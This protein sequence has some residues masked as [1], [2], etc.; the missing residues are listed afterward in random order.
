MSRIR[1]D[2]Q[3]RNGRHHPGAQTNGNGHHPEA[4]TEPA[5]SHPFGNVTVPALPTL[6]VSS[7]ATPLERFSELIARAFQKT[8]V[9]RRIPK[10]FRRIFRQQG[11][12]NKLTLEISRLLLQSDV[13]LEKKNEELVAYLTAQNYWLQALVKA[14]DDENRSVTKIASLVNQL[15]VKSAEL[16]KLNQVSDQKLGSLSESVRHLQNGLREAQQDSSHTFEKLAAVKS[17]ATALSHSIQQFQ[18]QSDQD[19]NQLQEL[20]RRCSAEFQRL[21]A[22]KADYA[23]VDE[24]LSE[25]H[26]HSISIQGRQ[27]RAEAEIADLKTS[28]SQSDNSL[29]ELRNARFG[30]EQKFADL[31]NE[32]VGVK[33]QLAAREA[34]GDAT[35]RELIPIREQLAAR[36]AQANAT[37]QELA[38]LR[39]Q[40]AAREAQ[41]DAT[42]RE[43]IPIREQLAAREAQANATAA[44]LIPIRERLA[45]REAQA[46]A[47]AESLVADTKWLHAALAAETKARE[48]VET[49]LQGYRA[50]FESLTDA[51]RKEVREERNDLTGISSELAHTKAVVEYLQKQNYGIDARLVAD[52]SFLKGELHLIKRDVDALFGEQGDLPAAKLEAVPERHAY[53]AFY[54]AFENKFRG[55]REV[56][57]ARAEPYL[58]DL[59]RAGVTRP[60]S[61]ILDLGCGRG[62]WLELLKENE[63]TCEGVDSNLCMV[64]ECHERGLAVTEGDALSFLRSKRKASYAAVTGFHIIEHLPFPV[65]MEVMREVYRVLRRGGVAI[66]ETPNPENVLVGSNRFYSDPTHL[67]PLPKEFSSFIMRTAGFKDVQIRPLHPDDNA[68]NAGDE[69]PQIQ[70]FIN[71]MF[72]GDQD[73]AVIAQK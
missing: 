36:E 68:L 65:L 63:L 15:T 54:L 34:Q 14:R 71:Q 57:K 12:F 46:N 9:N 62:E 19:R 58:S 30:A 1:A 29:Q 37:I 6:Y 20:E 40:F 8:D 64:A 50:S 18:I 31:H 61:R 13:R 53:D 59:S 3:K 2:I 39:V 7:T 11:G 60:R 35:A 38:S 28:R 72:F 55:T 43:L 42:A 70:Q 47:T 45:A 69:A 23:A 49:A 41:G 25:L 26:T 27:E 52:S 48:T 33:E 73:Y 24:Y 44:E 16:A 17:E 21:E 4:K 10:L 66:F 32:F 67:R 56:I 22:L 51:I 5:P